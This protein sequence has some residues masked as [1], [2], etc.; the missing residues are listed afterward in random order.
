[1]RQSRRARRMERHY[2]NSKKV[3]AFNLVSLMDIF[4]I[5]VFFLLV[6]SAEVQKIPTTKAVELPESATNVNP[7]ESIVVMVTPTDILVDNEIVAS[8]SDLKEAATATTAIDALQAA[9]KLQS[10]KRQVINADG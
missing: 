1:M 10:G 8:V 5:L 3:P 2:V 9:L 6:N 7:N 4:T